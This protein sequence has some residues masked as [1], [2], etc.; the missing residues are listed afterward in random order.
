[1]GKHCADFF[2]HLLLV[3]T[4]SVLQVDASSAKRYRDEDEGG[5]RH[6]VG[7]AVECDVFFHVIICEYRQLPENDLR[8][9]EGFLSR[10][11]SPSPRRG[12]RQLRILRWEL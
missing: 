4:G 9:N 2:L 6:C 8:R 7:N 3:L 12:L 11:I 5:E 10:S 1:V